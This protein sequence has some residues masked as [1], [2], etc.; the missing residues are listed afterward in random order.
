LSELVL[1]AFLTFSIIGLK[2]SNGR[3]ELTRVSVFTGG[4]K[5]TTTTLL[6]FI[7]TGKHNT[8]FFLPVYGCP[9]WKNTGILSSWPNEWRFTTN[10][11]LVPGQNHV[12]TICTI[13]ITKSIDHEVNLYCL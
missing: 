1:S 12:A 5:S 6:V 11:T 9:V 8:P 13:D 4:K 7:L 10:S 3:N 2:S